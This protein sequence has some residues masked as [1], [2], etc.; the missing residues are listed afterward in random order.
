[1][2]NKVAGKRKRGDAWTTAEIGAL[3]RQLKPVCRQLAA[4]YRE[5]LE[6]KASQI[7]WKPATYHVSVKQS[8]DQLARFAKMLKEGKMLKPE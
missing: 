3:S 5:M 6:L 2:P 7:S 4:T 8:A 1:M